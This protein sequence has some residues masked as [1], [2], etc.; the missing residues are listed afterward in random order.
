MLTSVLGKEK[1]YIYIFKKGGKVYNLDLWVKIKVQK[2]AVLGL[3]GKAEIC[4]VK[5]FNVWHCHADHCGSAFRHCL[6][7]PS[8][9][10]GM[11][12]MRDTQ[13]P[14]SSLCY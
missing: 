8:P 1:L 12:R 13:E 5:L 2:T 3:S 6:T 4:H 9:L 14:L 7:D 11:G 10:L